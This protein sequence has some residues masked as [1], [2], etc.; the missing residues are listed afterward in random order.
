MIGLIDRVPLIAEALT[1]LRVK[2]VTIDGDGVVCGLDG[3]LRPWAGTRH[4]PSGEA[5]HRP[6]CNSLS[7]SRNGF[8]GSSWSSNGL[9][10]PGDKVP[11]ADNNER[12]WR[13]RRPGS[14]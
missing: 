1:A 8:G 9:Q 14:V 2:S 3:R 11:R 7:E 13:T 12:R 10:K 5:L 6:R 4:R